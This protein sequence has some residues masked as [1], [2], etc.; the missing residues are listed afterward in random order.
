MTQA[1]IAFLGAGNIAQAIIGGLVNGGYPASLLFAAD[2]TEAQLARLAEG[3]NRCTSNAEAVSAADVVIFSVKPHFVGQVAEEIAGS[4][5]G[6]LMISVAAGIT[7]TLLS[8]KLGADAAI[9]RCMPNTPAL[10]GEGMTGLF[11]NPNVTAAQRKTGETVVSAIGKMLWFDTEDQLDMVTAVSGSGPAYFFIVME[12]MEQA[13]VA[14][15]LSAEASRT[16]VLQTALGAAK[17][18]AESDDPPATLRRNVTSPGGTTEAAINSLL[19]SGLLQ[20][21][22]SAIEAAYRR[23]I[24]LA[25]TDAP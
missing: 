20:D 2:P 10:I 23:S 25:A 7:T 16:L 13:A 18:A 19:S 8:D 3:V 14:L 5:Y 21:F 6:K 9:I 11:A 4:A 12:A 15:G 17:M 24:E 22:N 1:K